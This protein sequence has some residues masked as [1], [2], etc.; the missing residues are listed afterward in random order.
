M[1]IFK[2]CKDGVHKFVARYDTTPPKLGSVEGAGVVAFV[3][4]MTK[5]DYVK[6]VCVKCGKEVKR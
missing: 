2:S 3:K 5:Y 1:T 4:S 6:D